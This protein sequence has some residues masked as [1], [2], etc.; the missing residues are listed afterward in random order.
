MDFPEVIESLKAE[1]PEKAE[2]ILGHL[3]A[4][5]NEAAQHRIK[6]KEYEPLATRFRSLADHG[7]DLDGD[8]AEQIKAMKAGTQSVAD[9]A[10]KRISAIEK[11]LAE[12]EARAAEKESKLRGKTIE[13]AFGSRIAEAF[14]AAPVVLKQWAADRVL[15]IDES[16]KPI[17]RIGESVFDIDSGIAE[18]RKTF[19]EYAK[20]TQAGGSGSSGAKGGNAK[21]LTESQFSQLSSK[22]KA[23]FMADGGKII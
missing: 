6:A 23:S 11:K 7:I 3:N 16:E 13:A 9:E 17:V 15:D 5:K 8:I 4:L 10:G 21:Q 12:A 2:V 1:M 14:H 20:S 18:L 19:A 22:E